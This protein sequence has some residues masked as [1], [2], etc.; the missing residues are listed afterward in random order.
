[1]PQAARDYGFSTTNPTLLGKRK[2]LAQLLRGPH[3]VVV[4]ERDPLASRSGD[5]S[6][7]LAYPGNRSHNAYLSGAC[8]LLDR[9][10]RY[11]FCGV[12]DDDDLNKLSNVLGRNR[13]NGGE[14]RNGP[15][16]SRRNHN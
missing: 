4:E 7:A 15:H 2:L 11:S 13:R 9:I 8:G 5:T 16:S 14:K 12:V 6:G 3:V 10:E 1:M